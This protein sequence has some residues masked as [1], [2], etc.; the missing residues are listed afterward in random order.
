[1]QRPSEG[2]SDHS[3]YPPEVPFAFFGSSENPLDHPRKRGE[4]WCGQTGRE[5]RHLDGLPGKSIKPRA[6]ASHLF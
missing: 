6:L 4:R 5:A 3:T 2:G 1:M